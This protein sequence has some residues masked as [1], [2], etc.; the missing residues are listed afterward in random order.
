MKRISIFIVFLVCLSSLAFSQDQ[1]QGQYIGVIN[2][3]KGDLIHKYGEEKT[4]PVSRGIVIYSDSIIDYS[5]NY[6]KLDARIQ[7]LT[8]DRVPHIIS[9]FP[10]EFVEEE[11]S[12]L[13]RNEI[14]DL[15]NFI[16][17]YII[18]STKEEDKMFEWYCNIKRLDYNFAK[19]FK[20]IISENKSSI[21]E[22]SINPLIFKLKQGISIKEINCNVYELDKSNNSISKVKWIHENNDWILDFKNLPMEDEKIYVLE[23]TFMLNNGR[24]ETKKF[25]YQVYGEKKMKEIEKEA[26][27]NLPSD[28]TQFK[29]Q[30]EIIKNYEDYDLM[31]P[32]IKIRKEYGLIIKGLLG[33]IWYEDIE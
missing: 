24:E 11:Y 16:G 22:D 2:Y 33:E 15:L 9:S 31:L 1:Y 10:K 23:T 7:I 20:M 21:S 28:S 19:D 29:K 6:K 32:A 8:I 30:V 25:H 13:T 3:F 14:N 4:V 17:G 27:S 5:P 26:L 18:L 12:I